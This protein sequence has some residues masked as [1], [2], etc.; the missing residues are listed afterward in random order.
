M[1][2]ACSSE[3]VKEKLFQIINKVE[4]FGLSVLAVVCYVGSNFQKLFQELNLTYENPLFLHNGK[5]ILFLFNAP[6]I[7]K[8]I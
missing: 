8:A 6:H 1:I 2:Q 5:K 3:K 7:I 4:N